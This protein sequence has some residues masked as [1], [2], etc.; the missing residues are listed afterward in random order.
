M[1]VSGRW[2]LER[3]IVGGRKAKNG[4]NA[5]SVELRIAVFRDRRL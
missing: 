5:V 1:V 3:I 2:R 4:R